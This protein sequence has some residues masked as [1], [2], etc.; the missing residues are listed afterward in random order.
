MPD[1]TV[2]RLGNLSW[3]T[4]GVMGYLGSEGTLRRG[5][6]AR[7]NKHEA[8]EWARETLRG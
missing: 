8:Q 5:A 4:H 3:P 7:Y 2:V 6:M 1:D